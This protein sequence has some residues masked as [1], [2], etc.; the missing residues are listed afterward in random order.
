[1]TWLA[2]LLRRVAVVCLRWA[3]Y[4]DPLPVSPAHAQANRMLLVRGLYCAL[5]AVQP[6]ENVTAAP[7][8]ETENQMSASSDTL[9]ERTRVTAILAK[10]QGNGFTKPDCEAALIA[11]RRGV[12]AAAFKTPATLT[13]I[14]D[15]QNLTVVE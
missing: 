11:V 3:Q 6:I 13:A 15:L 4:L 7:A 5:G 1:M 12:P 10:I 14:A 9:A 8:A 2:S